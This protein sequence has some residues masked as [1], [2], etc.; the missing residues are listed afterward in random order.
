MKDD[1]DK[2]N[3]IMSVK[4]GDEDVS[5]SIELMNTFLVLDFNDKNEIVGFEIFDYMQRVEEHQKRIN[6]IFNKEEKWVG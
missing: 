5:H 1:Y 6:K 4:F 3:D 2:E